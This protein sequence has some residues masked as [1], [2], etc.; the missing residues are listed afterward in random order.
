MLLIDIKSKLLYNNSIKSVEAT[1]I[2]FDPR[3]CYQG[4]RSSGIRSFYFV[5]L[6]GISI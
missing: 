3:N 1:S 6:A 5:R 2:K 4:L